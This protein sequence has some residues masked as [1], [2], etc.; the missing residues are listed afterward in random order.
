M[1]RKGLPV[2]NRMPLPPRQWSYTGMAG[3]ETNNISPR[4]QLLSVFDRIYAPL[5]Q[6]QLSGRTSDKDQL[7]R[8][9]E[10]Q[11]E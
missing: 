5:Q 1:S 7:I 9:D 4:V 10:D 11:N 2:D 8:I 3:L 6:L